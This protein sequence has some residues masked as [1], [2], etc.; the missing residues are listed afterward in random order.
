MLVVLF[1]D[2]ICDWRW[3]SNNLLLFSICLE[4]FNICLS[5]AFSF[6]SLW[7]IKT[8]RKKKR[9]DIVFLSHWCFLLTRQFWFCYFNNKLPKMWRCYVCSALLYSWA[10]SYI[11]K[12][13]ISVQILLHLLN[14]QRKPCLW[15]GAR[16]LG[17]VGVR[18]SETHM[19]NRS[20]TDRRVAFRSQRTHEETQ[21]L[22]AHHPPFSRSRL[23]NIWPQ[24]GPSFTSSG[25]L[26]TCFR[27]ERWDQ[28][29]VRRHKRGRTTKCV[30]F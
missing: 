21:T 28:Y 1:A 22:S 17:Y 8:V 6:V 3:D 5:K 9:H 23:S 14:N 13:S 2:V 29:S 15:P 27:H 12:R 4:S 10:V 11:F 30:F 20:K 24:K 25:S 18:I 7:C 16:G 26:C 19:D